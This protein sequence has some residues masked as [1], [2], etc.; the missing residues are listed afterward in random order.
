M[1]RQLLCTVL[2]PTSCL[3]VM[4]VVCAT[5]LGDAVPHNFN[6]TDWQRFSNSVSVRMH[7]TSIYTRVCVL[8]TAH[9]MH[10]YLCVPLLHV[11]KLLY[12]YWLGWVAGSMLC[13]GWELTLIWCYILALRLQPQDPLLSY[14]RETRKMGR[15]ACDLVIIS[16][17][18]FPL[19]VTGAL[20]K[21]G[22]VTVREYM[23]ANVLVTLVTSVKSVVCGAILATS[24]S[25]A[26]V[27]GVSTVVAFS[28]ALPSMCTMYVSSQTLFLVMRR[29]VHTSECDDAGCDSDD[30]R[31]PVHASESD[32]A[33]RDSDDGRRPS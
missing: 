21:F 8:L 13:C 29:P 23:T 22:D 3:V 28:S 27:L 19:Q 6:S 1:S 15:L 12:G 24:P 7:A 18:S 30:E 11:T 16:M 17:S 26:E 32:D 5:Q 25:A 14:T 31:R 2:L 33:G 4:S 10:M 9:V 20:V